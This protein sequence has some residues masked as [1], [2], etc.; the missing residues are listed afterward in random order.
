MPP[1][2]NSPALTLAAAA[3]A[4]AS[5]AGCSSAG[6]TAPPDRTLTVFAA[7]SL[8]AA[9]TDIGHDFEAAHPGTRVAFSFDGSAAL[10]D[11]LK[12]G[13]PADVF[14]SADDANM[15]K[16][17]DA[18][19]VAGTPQRFATNVLTLVVAPGNPAGITGLDAS[20]EGKKLVIC[21]V[22]VPCGTATATLAT[23]LGVT[24]RPV[25]KE[26]KVTDVLGKVTSGE[27]DAGVVYA[28]DAL[29]AGARVTSIALPGADKIVN[30]YPIA[31]TA[32]ARQPEAAAQFVAHVTGDQGRAALARYGFGQG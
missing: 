3:L 13:A 12:G 30:H 22:G 28:T 17:T 19:L 14:A 25:S 6:P 31:V 7:S 15:K 20:L 4:L 18:H 16:A 1:R 24:L 23:N 11:Q 10:V 2:K 8:K 5:L 21:A 29:A 26:Q 27:A 9:F 32:A